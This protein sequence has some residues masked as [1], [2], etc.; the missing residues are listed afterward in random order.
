[1]PADGKGAKGGDVMTKTHAIGAA[2]TYGK[3]YLLG[4]IFN[5]AVGGDVDD[6]GNSNGGRQPSTVAQKALEEINGFET[7]ADLAL[8]KKNKAAGIEKMVSATEWNEIVRLWNRRAEH[9][10]KNGA[11][12]ATNMAETADAGFPGDR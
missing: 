1:M 9:F 8:W 3:R 2:V 12:P 4:M 10:R 7:G 6:D 11:G 5:I